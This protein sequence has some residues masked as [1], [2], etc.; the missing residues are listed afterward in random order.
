MLFQ[1]GVLVVLLSVILGY[2]AEGGNIFVLFQP[3]TALIIVGSAMGIFLIS[4]PKSLLKSIWYNLPKVIKGSPYTKF[5]YI[6]C[7]VF[8]FEV[9][10]YA[11]SHSILALEEHIENPYKSSLFRKHPSILSKREAV[12]FFCDYMR[13]LVLGYDNTFELEN[14]MEEQINV[15]KEYIN[16][17]SGALYRIGD[18]LPALGILAAVLG[19][20][21]A[22]GSIASPP[23]VLGHK[24]ASALIGTFFGVAIAYC[25]VNPIAAK[26]HKFGYDEA[27]LLECIKAG[28]IAHARGNPPSISIEFARQ[29]ISVN[30]K[31]SFEDVEKA[32]ENRKAALKKV[33]KYG[34]REERRAEAG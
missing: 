15:R 31:P 1:V 4:N 10:R 22:M 20:I 32:I 18:T 11:R 2:L 19:V 5:E 13:M 30:M 16:E 8:L 9:F 27:K 21:N 7:L 34:R 29:A 14:M 23:D 33:R 24:I 6:Q 12:V 25:V 26:L 3:F 17:I 28:F